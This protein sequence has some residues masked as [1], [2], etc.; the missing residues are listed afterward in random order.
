[1]CSHPCGDGAYKQHGS[2]AEDDRP[3]IGL[4]ECYPGCTT[5]CSK[6][7]KKTMSLHGTTHNTLSLTKTVGSQRGTHTPIPE[8]LACNNNNMFV[9][10]HR[11]DGWHTTH[12][13]GKG[14]GI[15]LTRQG[16]QVFGLHAKGVDTMRKILCQRL[17]V[18]VLGGG[19]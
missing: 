17:L 15:L 9:S 8:R 19:K 5:F 10:Y 2:E 3:D 14:R 16:I 18:L 13:M 4:H 6:K 11:C 12:M 7:K 1:M